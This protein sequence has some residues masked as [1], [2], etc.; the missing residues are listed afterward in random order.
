MRGN[1]A[2]TVCSRFNLHRFACV[3]L[4]RLSLTA[5]GLKVIRDTVDGGKVAGA[6]LMLIDY[7]M[8]DERGNR[9]MISESGTAAMALIRL[10]G[11]TD[12]NLKQQHADFMSTAP[13]D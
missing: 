5:V 8:N 11:E 1:D 13:S 4:Y 12:A 2:W 6:L 9:I 7:A 10:F 3:A